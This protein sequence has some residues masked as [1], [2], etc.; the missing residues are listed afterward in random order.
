[1]GSKTPATT[2]Q[3]TKVELSP[4]Q[5][6]IYDIAFPKA[7]EYASKPLEQF[8]GSGIAELS[9]EEK[10]AQA[11]YLGSAAPTGGALATQAANAQSQLLDPSFMLDVSNNQYLKDA[12]EANAG[13]VSRQLTE[14]ALPA[15]A[16]GATM[17][18][19]MY[20]GG[21]SREGIAQGQAIGRASTAI[22]DS[23]AKMMLDAYNTGLGGLQ[24]AIQANPN[25]QAQQLFAPDVMATVGAQNRAIE[26][27]KLDEEI[28]K[29]YTGQAL[30][31]VQAQ[32]L[33]GLISG[34][35]GGTTVGQ[36]TGSTPSANPM[37]AGLGGAASGAAIG[38]IVPGVGTAIG[39][40]VGLL[41]SILGNR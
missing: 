24:Q 23:N 28:R 32:E 7:Q 37:M 20:S 9:P 34:M 16:Q 6:S 12:M 2:T 1:M 29:F 31:F 17:A 30:P 33:M 19:G 21:S 22:S 38:S 26:Q 5:K 18:G 13:I 3:T 10:A 15:V 27:A 25:V 11:A 14:Q 8:A 35:P 36:V 39:A 4:E 40:G 41:A